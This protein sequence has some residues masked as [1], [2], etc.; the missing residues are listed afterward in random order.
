MN[1][2]SLLGVEENATYEEIAQAYRNHINAFHPDH[3]RGPNIQ[4]AEQKTRELNEAYNTLR[5]PIT[6]AEYDQSLR[7]A[8]N[9]P[10]AASN[11][12]SHDCSQA[13]NYDALYSFLYTISKDFADNEFPEGKNGI[14]ASFLYALF[15]KAS[16]L[17][18]RKLDIPDTSRQWVKNVLKD[19]NLNESEMASFIASYDR[20]FSTDIWDKKDFGINSA[21]QGR[22]RGILLIISAFSVFSCSG[23]QSN[24]FLKY[25]KRPQIE[26]L[27]DYGFNS[28]DYLESSIGKIYGFFEHIY[29]QIDWENVLKQ[30]SRN[31]ENISL[32][33][34]KNN[35]SNIKN[36]QD[37]IRRESNLKGC[38]GAFLFALIGGFITGTAYY[39]GRL[40][41]I[42]VIITF[43]LAVYG[44]TKL[45]KVE[46]FGLMKV[47]VCLVITFV[48]AAVAVYCS[49]GV[50]YYNTYLDLYNN[51]S[52]W[53]VPSL[54]KVLLHYLPDYLNS[55]PETFKAIISDL[56]K[57]IGLSLV[58]SGFIIVRGLIRDRLKN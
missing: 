33:E 56:I 5:N 28:S 50:M 2:Y 39:F 1:Y 20:L 30:D 34:K 31:C 52:I 3:Y 46:R 18:T 51:G 4:F 9:N 32:R 40:G 27:L 6:R 42:G 13:I 54:V 58:V 16:E 55:S 14:K 11:N 23:Y 38:F 49:V 36:T 10:S 45:G 15:K 53:Y 47:L 44:Y 24:D 35:Y 25:V 26:K 41:V 48:I 22:E 17:V 21:A 43:L 57:S 8:S 37:Y 29:T 12:E 7:A 19:S